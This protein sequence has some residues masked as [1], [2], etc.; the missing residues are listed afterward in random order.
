MPAYDLTHIPGREHYSTQ[1]LQ[2]G[3][4]FSY[5]HQIQS[6]LSFKP[7]TIIEVGAGGGMVTNALRTAGITVT[8]IDVQPDLNPD[9]TAPVTDLPLSDAQ[10]DVSLCC[11]VLEHLPFT[12][13]ERALRELWRVCRRGM[14]ISLPDASPF[15]EIHLRLPKLPKI[16]W[17]GSRHRDPGDSWRRMKWDSSGHYWEIGYSETSLHTVM[18]SMHRVVKMSPKTW[19]VP[20]KHYHRF[21]CFQKTK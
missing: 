5:A 19:R 21:F 3:R 15:Y 6:V 16:S 17:H 8:T 18:N 2:D 12:E 7:K 1:Y 11:Q 4:I 13:F 9:L 10:V 14:V 20:E